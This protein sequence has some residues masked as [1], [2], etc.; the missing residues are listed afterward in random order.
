MYAKRYAVIF[1]ISLLVANG[2]TFW[3]AI[4]YWNTPTSCPAYIADISFSITGST[5]I[6]GPPLYSQMQFL[7]KPG[8]TAYETE[9][10]NA[11]RFGNNLT[12]YFASDHFTP[13]TVSQYL[14]M[15]NPFSGQINPVP[16]NQTGITITLQN[17]TFQGIHVAKFL[18]KIAVSGSAEHASYMLAIPCVGP[19]LV[20]TVGSIPYIGPL[21][22]GE[23]QEIGII[24][25]NVVA[26]IAAAVISI[27]LSF[28]W[29]RKAGFKNA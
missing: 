15:I 6:V 24:V 20:L 8:S 17:L 1:A 11:T 10:Y 13:Y 25:N 19:G 9:T 7:V 27:A 18:Y 14:W 22:Y 3:P 2:Y 4:V 5:Q 26:F 12:A 16:F 29:H 23:V 28:Y 21:A